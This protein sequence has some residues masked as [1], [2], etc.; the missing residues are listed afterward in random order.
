M[1]T[2]D[3]SDRRCDRKGALAVGILAIAVFAV[4]IFFGV[5]YSVGIVGALRILDGDVPYRDFWTIYVPGHFYLL[6]FLFF[7]FGRHLVIANAAKAVFI[8]ASGSMMFLIARD[9]KMTRQVAATVAG[10]FVLMLWRTNGGLSTY[11]PALL[12]ILVGLRALTRS[13]GSLSVQTGLAAGA[14]VGVAAWFKHDVA[15]YAGLAMVLGRI[16]DHV[17]SNG[18]RRWLQTTRDALLIGAGAAAMVL[19]VAAWCWLVAGR[20][21]FQDVIW[22]PIFEFPKLEHVRF[23]SFL[24][25]LRRTTDA[26]DAAEAVLNWCRFNIQLVLW[27]GWIV[28]LVRN[29]IRRTSPPQSGVGFLV[30]SF[31]LFWLAALVRNHTHPFTIAAISL[32]IGGVAWTKSHALLTRRLRLAPGLVALA[33]GASLL[34]GSAKAVGRVVL[35]WPGSRFSSIP[36]LWGLRVPA[37]D[38]EYYEPIA[39]LVQRSIPTNERIYVGMLRHDVLVQSNP[40]VYAVVGRRGASRYDELHPAV[41]DRADVQSEIAD[42]IDR[43]KVRL[44]VLWEIGAVTGRLDQVK[45]ERAHDLPNS[46]ASVLDRFLEREFRPVAQYGEYHVR[47]RRPQ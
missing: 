33:Y 38:L 25:A 17:C 18:Q 20:D 40:M 24:P 1:T 11:E 46:G 32:L 41:A 42:A 30:S 19:P 12:F 8:A 6:A 2:S 28:A 45:I 43:G 7:L 9:L 14:S 15:A 31:A 29:R 21:A 34:L 36:S 26:K 47:W 35:D 5:P 37:R 16:V 13:D 27:L 4:P 39:G 44:A 10:L 3:I 22:F 23:P